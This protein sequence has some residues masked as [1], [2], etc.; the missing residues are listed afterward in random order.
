MK[1]YEHE[2]VLFL[3]AFRHYR[4]IRRDL[5]R[6][7]K[8]PLMKLTYSQLMAEKEKLGQA[9]LI[10]PLSIEL[11]TKMELLLEVENG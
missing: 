7:F 6:V 3:P 2:G 10:Q 1:P 8:N 4:N 9:L 11:R 5:V